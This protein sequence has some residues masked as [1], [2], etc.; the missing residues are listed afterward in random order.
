[1]ILIATAVPLHYSVQF[2]ASDLNSNSW[3]NFWGAKCTI[4]DP[5]NNSIPDFSD[6]FTASDPNTNSCT[7][8]SVQFTVF[9]A[10]ANICI[11]LFFI[12]SSVILIPTPVS[13]IAFSLQ[14][15]IILP[16][17]YHVQYSF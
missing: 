16:T 2:T 10:N 13:R 15:M 12:L 3:I 5:N 7:D 17:F 9:D 8:Y 4:C 6:Q 14:P 11:T 1:V